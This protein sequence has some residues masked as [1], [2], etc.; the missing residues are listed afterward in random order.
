LP[1]VEVGVL[2]GASFP[3]EGRVVPSGLPGGR[4]AVTVHRGDYAAL[5]RAHA[6]V[7]R[8]AE[9]QALELSGGRWEIYGH[10]RDDLREPETEVYYLLR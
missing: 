7:I 9:E 1:S 5:G 3:P 6:A 2:V 10:W 4:V 8:F